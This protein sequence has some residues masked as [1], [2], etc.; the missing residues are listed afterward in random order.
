MARENHANIEFFLSPHCQYSISVRLSLRHAIEALARV[1]LPTLLPSHLIVVLLLLTSESFSA[2]P[3]SSPLAVLL[4]LSPVAW[5]VVSRLTAYSLSLLQLSSDLDSLQPSNFGLLPLLA[6]FLGSGPASLL[7]GSV[8]GLVRLA[9][10]CL[11]TMQDQEQTGDAG[12]A[13]ASGSVTKV[14]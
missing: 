5:L 7:T 1:C 3:H 6:F 9:A 10:L 13:G 11:D 8:W 14:M 12:A 4:S 2:C